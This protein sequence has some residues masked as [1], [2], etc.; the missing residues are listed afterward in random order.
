MQTKDIIVVGASAGGVEALRRL[1]AALP[2]DLP[3]SVLVVQHLSPSAR[4]VLPQLLNKVGPLP[5]AAP[6]DGE[7]LQVGRIYVA[8]PDHHLLVR[9]G[10]VLVRRGPYE[11]R[12][13]PAVNPLF[14]SAAIAYGSRVIGVVLTGLL[15]DGTDGLIAIKAVGGT[16]VVQDPA[17]AEWPSMPRN[18]LQRDH[19]D[20]AVALDDMGTLLS[21]LSREEAGPSIPAPEDYMVEDRIAAQDFASIEPGLETPGRASPISCPDCGGVLNQIETD[22]EI[23]FRCQVG[24]AFT[25]LGLA[26]TQ[27]DELERALGV[28]VRT[29]R[30]RMRLFDQMKVNA[31]DRGMVH[32]KARWA[33]ASAEAEQ[34]VNVLERAMAQL[35]KPAPDGVG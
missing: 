3:A 31:S 20:H 5:A 7:A 2:A 23:R 10:R 16:S 24:H 32:A 17:D 13:R 11:N 9:P 34:F 14:R 27:S 30:D 19:V 15:D 35:K 18:A 33:T 25:P 26:A 21:R 8:G 12:T 1:C 28:A 6:V 4:S 22:K 29:H